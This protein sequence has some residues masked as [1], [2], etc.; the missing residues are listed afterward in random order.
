MEIK[1]KFKDNIADF[2]IRVYGLGSDGSVSSVK[3][4]IKILGK[5]T[6][7]F[8]Q[9]YFDYDSKK[10][11]SLTVSHLRSSFLP[12]TAPFNARV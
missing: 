10:S 7:S 5:E 1:E 12:I 4:S 9:G 8:M 3:N 2:A 11:G 6:T